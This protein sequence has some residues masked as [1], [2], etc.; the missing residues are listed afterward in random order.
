MGKMMQASYDVFGTS[1]ALKTLTGSYVADS[2]STVLFR[3]MDAVTLEVS[4]TTGNATGEFIDVQILLSNDPIET[5]PSNFYAWV[6]AVQAD[7][8]PATEWDASGAGL[9]MPKDVATP[10][11]NTNYKRSVTLNPEGA[12]WVKVMVKSSAG[13]TFGAAWVRATVTGN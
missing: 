13:G 1:S 5:T 6:P 10:A 7:A 11:A 8:S 4:F 3:Y 9:R 12:N 2:K